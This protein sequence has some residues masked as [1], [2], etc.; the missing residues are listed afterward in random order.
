MISPPSTNPFLSVPGW[1]L[2]STPSGEIPPS[3]PSCPLSG[4]G[5][6]PPFGGPPPALLTAALQGARSQARAMFSRPVPGATPTSPTPSPGRSPALR[7]STPPFQ[8]GGGVPTSPP[9]SPVEER[10]AGHIS[11]IPYEESLPSSPPTTHHSPHS[12]PPASRPPSPPTLGLSREEEEEDMRPRSPSLDSRSS[13]GDAEEWIAELFR[14]RGEVDTDSEGE[15]LPQVRS[16]EVTPLRP[17]V[18]DPALTA[19]AAV[20]PLPPYRSVSEGEIPTS[21]APNASHWQKHQTVQALMAPYAEAWRRA[22]RGAPVPFSPE[23]EGVSFDVA[24]FSALMRRS[25]EARV[26]PPME[27]T[28]GFILRQRIGLGERVAFCSDLHGDLS[29]FLDFLMTL[30]AT[31][32]MDDQFHLREGMHCVVGGDVC[33]RAVYGTQLLTLILLLLNENPERFHLLRGNHES[34]EMHRQNQALYLLGGLY[35]RDARLVQL[36]QNPEARRSL[37]SWYDTLPLSLLLVHP[38]GLGLFTHAG[39][40]PRADLFPLLADPSPCALLPLPLGRGVSPRICAIGPGDPLYESARAIQ[41]LYRKYQTGGG[42]RDAQLLEENGFSEPFGH[43]LTPINWMD[44]NTCRSTYGSLLERAY[45]VSLLDLRH[46]FNV[47]LSPVLPILCARGHSHVGERLSS[48]S[49]T[50]FTHS[51]ARRIASAQPGPDGWYGAGLILTSGPQG[52]E[53]LLLRAPREGK[54]FLG[55]PPA[56]V[57]APSAVASSSSSE[58]V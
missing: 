52:W 28:C 39:I 26:L 34:I 19:R 54:S 5:S 7:G 1:S 21:S 31:G 22:A 38:G 16:R 3:L 4:A 49:L 20:R 23:E 57:E 6:T 48:E 50:V 55:A 24:L 10:R 11:G 25:R 27:E 45:A 15:G 53:E 44:L 30:V 47:V 41:R 40:D 14:C 58:T 37:E 29:S 18:E 43:R 12:T 56:P 33:D 35:T 32:M 42:V 51:I 2:G 46:Y 17:V 8:G 36:L 13:K 9:R